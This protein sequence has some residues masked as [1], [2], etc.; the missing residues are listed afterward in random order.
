MIRTPTCPY[1]DRPAELVTGATIYRGRPDLMHL[2]FWC[3]HQCDAYVGCHKA[4]S[5][6]F[7]GGKKIVHTGLEP[8]GRLA[9][10]QLRR[11]KQAAHAAF[12]PLWMQQGKQR[13]EARRSAY[14]WLAKE[15]GISEANCHIGM[16]D[17]E[18]CLATVQACQGNPRIQ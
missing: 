18:L 12:D 5:W 14:A 2:K 17:V 10:P 1:C 4:G 15:L 13:G 6:R 9:D 8:L 11:A 7:E 16:F 3:C